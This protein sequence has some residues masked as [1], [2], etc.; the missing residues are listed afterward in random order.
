M[1]VNYFIPIL[2]HLY[3]KCTEVKD[4][5]DSNSSG[6]LLSINIYE[7]DIMGDL[8]IYNNDAVQK[9]IKLLL[10]ERIL[11]K[12][13]RSF[14]DKSKVFYKVNIKDENAF[15]FAESLIKVYH[16]Y[17]S[18]ISIEDYIMIG[19]SWYSYKRSRFIKIM[20]I[21]GISEDHQEG[22]G[23]ILLGEGYFVAQKD[24]SLQMVL[25]RWLKYKFLLVNIQNTMKEE[26]S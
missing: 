22:I 19:E 12:S 18:T 9:A 20:N 2:A 10:D 25:E 15:M 4:S 21:L 5:W 14:Y 23:K 13:T 6:D 3:N 17:E 7:E 24:H 8:V 26:I 1:E 11:I 16:F